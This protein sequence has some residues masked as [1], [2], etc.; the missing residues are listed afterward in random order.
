M[1]RPSCEVTRHFG[2]QVLVTALLTTAGMASLGMRFARWFTARNGGGWSTGD[3]A[4]VIVPAL[5]LAGLVSVAAYWI[6][7]SAKFD[8]G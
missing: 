5:V 3:L 8:G 4:L 6:Y 1:F 7:V 2:N